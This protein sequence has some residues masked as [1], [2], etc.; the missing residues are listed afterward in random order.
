[1]T[2]PGTFLGCIT[3]TSVDGLDLAIVHIDNDG[4]MTMGPAETQPLGDD[5]RD[6]LLALGR[7]AATGGTD[8]LDDLGAVDARL[9][10]GIGQ[11]ILRFL[12]HHDI[13]ASAVTAIG[14]H[15]QTVRHRP[16]GGVGEAAFTLQIGDPNRI[17][18]TTGITTV[19]D[20]RRRDMAAGGHGAPLVPPFHRALFAG[21]DD[22]IVVLNI[23]GIANIS[24]LSEK[25]TSGFDTGPGNGLMDAWC[26]RCR[27]EPF[28]R[29][30]AWAASGKVV[31]DLLRRCLD[32]DYFKIAPPKSTGREYFHEAW[33]EPHLQGEKPEDVQATL[34]ALTATTVADAIARWAP[35]AARVVVCGGGRL[36]ATLMA[37]LA[38]AAS[39]DVAP[40]EQSGIDGDSVEAAAFA[41]LAS[42]TLAGLPGNEPAVTGASGPRVLGAIYPGG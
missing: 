7:P 20:F 15:G 10:E 4:A 37:A 17:A 36:N 21:Q 33:L 27:G 19:A 14:S 2:A 9:G 22:T 5:L 29:D 13:E 28:D 8:R 41:W 23:G 26:A 24:I 31:P 38:D 12:S 40:C 34:C 32:D 6:A 16:P 25:T 3:G 39:A 42:R 35:D 11:A 18:E 30:G 1:M